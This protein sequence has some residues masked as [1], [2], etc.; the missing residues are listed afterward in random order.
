MARPKDI[1]ILRLRILRICRAVLISNGNYGVPNHDYTFVGTLTQ[2]ELSEGA[3][4]GWSGVMTLCRGEGRVGTMLII[5]ASWVGAWV[6]YALGRENR[7]VMTSVNA[8]VVG[9]WGLA[10]GKKTL[11][12]DLV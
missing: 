5:L 9:D 6:L 2:R 8:A 3:G 10:E 11:I 12:V 7:G 1:S 4:N